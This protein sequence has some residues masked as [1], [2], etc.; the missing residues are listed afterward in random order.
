MLRSVWKENLY[1]LFKQRNAAL[2]MAFGLL[3]TNML[4]GVKVYTK[5]ERVI[6]VPAYLKQ[7]FWAEGE[8]ISKEYLEEMSLFFAN[9]ML[10]VSA[11]SMSYQRE[12]VLRYVSPEFH[13]DLKH[14]LID[15][16]DKMR[17]QGLT[18]TFR[19]QEV[20]ADVKS[21]EVIISGTLSQ[22]ISG[23]RVG[24]VTESYKAIFEY[25]SGILLLKGFEVVDE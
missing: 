12:V 20:K 3:V 24:Q 2:V 1:S 25:S 8:N 19:A 23:N 9:L 16:E 5:N 21:G 10:N 6:V 14:R 11:E 4:L 18:T 22:Y 17:Q 15:E 13:G 7:S